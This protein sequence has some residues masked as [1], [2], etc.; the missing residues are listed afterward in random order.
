LAFV[1]AALSEI[2]PTLN[3]AVVLTG[4]QQTIEHE[5]TDI[6]ANLR[7][8]L[9]AMRFLSPGVYVAFGGVVIEGSVV[10]KLSSKRNNAFVAVNAEPIAVFD[11]ETAFVRAHVGREKVAV[12]P[13]AIDTRF[14]S[15]I[16]IE[17]LF[18]GYAPKDLDDALRSEQKHGVVLR[19]YGLGNIPIKGEGSILPVLR[20]WAT[21]KPIVDTTL[22]IDGGT[23]L[24]IY[25][26]GRAARDAGVLEAGTLSLELATVRLMHL[27][28]T[29]SNLDQIRA[30]WDNLLLY[31]SG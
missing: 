9:L 3:K 18:P 1:A 28:G 22:C 11:G 25:E 29:K 13:T 4:S 27:L 12:C 24:S 14:N 26:A 15:N 8:A 31:E 2:F 10:S 7:T 19:A 23:D 21:Q 16:R 20:E 30:T 17:T 6:P 5:A